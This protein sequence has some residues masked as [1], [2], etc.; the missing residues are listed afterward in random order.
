MSP[1]SSSFG[2]H[3]K[4]LDCKK[5]GRRVKPT[6]RL[7]N[8]DHSSPGYFSKKNK[9]MPLNIGLP[10]LWQCEQSGIH[11]SRLSTIMGTQEIKNLVTL[12]ANDWDSWSLVLFF[13]LNLGGYM[14]S[15]TTGGFLSKTTLFSRWSL[16][17]MQS[18]NLNY[19]K[20]SPNSD[21]VRVPDFRSMNKI[22]N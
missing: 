8:G 22:I 9:E 17:R 10:S 4:K 5:V 12:A 20:R 2:R 18:I 11:W 21:W 16:H 14:K 15:L 13:N 6:F 7:L 1:L 19:L 3:N